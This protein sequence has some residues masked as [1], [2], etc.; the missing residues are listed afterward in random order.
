MT[1]IAQRCKEAGIRRET[2]YQRLKRGKKDLFAPPYGDTKRHVPEHIKPLLK[3]NGISRN[4]YLLRINRGWTEFE[5]ANI[6]PYAEVY[7]VN[8]Q[9]VYSLLGRTR[10]NRFIFLINE[11]GLSFEEALQKVD[12][13]R[14]RVK[15]YRD[16]KSLRQWCIEKNKSYW[17]EWNKER[18]KLNEQRV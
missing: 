17:K 18:K 9:S 14:D 4:N 13:P 3:K 16:G 10:Y 5:A 11:E 2:Y 12:N 6:K 1:S 7:K 8:G 15:Y